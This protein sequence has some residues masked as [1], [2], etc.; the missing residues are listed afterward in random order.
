[1]IQD[2]VFEILLFCYSQKTKNPPPGS[3][4]RREF[5]FCV[6][7]ASY[8][9]PILPRPVIR[10]GRRIPRTFVDTTGRP[11]A[12]A[13]TSKIGRVLTKSFIW[14]CILAKPRRVG[15]PKPGLFSM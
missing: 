15:N 14:L 12:L 8:A 4:G 11:A 5:P 1:M 6:S 9:K 2:S 10:P 7:F 13:A 3:W